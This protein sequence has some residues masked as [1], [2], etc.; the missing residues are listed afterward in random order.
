MQHVTC[1]CVA[2][3]PD[4]QLSRRD[5]MYLSLTTSVLVP[6]PSIHHLH[7]V[8]FALCFLDYDRY[9]YSYIYWYD[10][11]LQR[12]IH[13]ERGAFTPLVFATNGMCSQECSRALKNLVGLIINK[14]SDLRYSSVMARLRCCISFLLLKWFA[15][16]FRGCR[17][18]YLRRR[19]R[20]SFLDQCRLHDL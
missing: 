5:Y 1:T 13:V 2:K 9:Y 8:F 18:S 7:Y 17:A 19:A 20:S 10:S 3:C 14:H 4:N 11:Y 12:V 6:F 15:T 16:C